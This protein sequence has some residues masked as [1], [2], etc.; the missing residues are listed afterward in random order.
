MGFSW[1]GSCVPVSKKSK[2]IQERK[3]ESSGYTISIYENASRFQMSNRFVVIKSNHPK[4]IDPFDDRRKRDR[5][6]RMGIFTARQ[7]LESIFSL[8]PNSGTSENSLLTYYG[9]LRS[10]Y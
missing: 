8:C 10:C 2:A 6:L 3:K 7:L 4:E 1:P 5:P 9:I